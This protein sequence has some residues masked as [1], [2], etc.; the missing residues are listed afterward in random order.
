MR[1]PRRVPILHIVD[2]AAA[3]LRRTGSE[4]WRIGVMGTQAALRL[5]LY[6]DRLGAL[7]WDCIVP[8]TDEMDRLVSTGDRGW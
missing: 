3:D 8:T 5:R 2:A 4:G 7:G 1:R 6:Q